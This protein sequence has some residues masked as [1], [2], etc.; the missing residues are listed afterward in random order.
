MI[1]NDPKGHC[2]ESNEK[3]G[4]KMKKLSKSFAGSV[5]TVEKFRVYCAC[6]PVCKCACA[7]VANATRWYDG[8]K[9]DVGYS[10]NVRVS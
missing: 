5:N 4:R 8:Y 7:T 1:Y 9:L 3:G 10:A 2:I 6:D